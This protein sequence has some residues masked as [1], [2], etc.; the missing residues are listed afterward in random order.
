MVLFSCRKR[1][2]KIL[3]LL[4]RVY[5]QCNQLRVIL[6]SYCNSVIFKEIVVSI[7]WWRKLHLTL[8]TACLNLY[9]SQSL[10]RDQRIMKNWQVKVRTIED[11]KRRP[12]MVLYA[13]DGHHRSHIIINS[14]QIMNIFHII[15]LATTVVTQTHCSRTTSGAIQWT[16]Q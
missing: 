11:F 12:K 8:W 4:S 10:F 1:L 7:S 15:S 16:Q 14:N 9:S 6:L 13:S 3:Q 5:S 2:S